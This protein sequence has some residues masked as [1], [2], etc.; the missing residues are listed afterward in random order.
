ML[1]VNQRRKPYSFI[2]ISY[3]AHFL[4]R[5]KIQIKVCYSFGRSGRQFFHSKTCSATEVLRLAKFQWSQIYERQTGSKWN[6]TNFKHTTN[7]WNNSNVYIRCFIRHSHA[8]NELLQPYFQCCVKIMT[9]TFR[10]RNFY[11]EMRLICRIR[12]HLC[13]TLS[14]VLHCST[15]F[16]ANH[17]KFFFLRLHLLVFLLFFVFVLASNKVARNAPVC[18]ALTRFYIILMRANA[19][20]C[21]R[22]LNLLFV[23]DVKSDAFIGTYKTYAYHTWLGIQV[24]SCCTYGQSI[25]NITITHLLHTKPLWAIS[26]TLTTDDKNVFPKWTIN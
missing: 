8:C 23:Q 12:T 9:D 19:T 6:E 20:C 16:N 13:H 24:S 18:P 14:C 21:T 15:Q 22:I 4:F 3:L 25:R 2:L 17:F 26:L 11:N 1:A 10:W 5:F 7:G